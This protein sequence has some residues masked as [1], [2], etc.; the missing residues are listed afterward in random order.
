MHLSGGLRT[1]VGIM[2]YPTCRNSTAGIKNGAAG[3]PI[4]KPDLLVRVAIQFQ[5]L[6]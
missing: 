5:T 4:R 3:K 2:S 1:R 6:D